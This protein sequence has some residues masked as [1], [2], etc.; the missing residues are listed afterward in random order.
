MTAAL[1]PWADESPPAPVTDAVPVPGPPV[2]P[3]PTLPPA[4]ADGE[5]F[6]DALATPPAQEA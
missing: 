4:P 1:D 3:P 6:A 5:T 2:A